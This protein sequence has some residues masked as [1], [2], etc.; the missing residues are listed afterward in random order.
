M[1]KMQ[2]SFSRRRSSKVDSRYLSRRSECRCATQ[3]LASSPPVFAERRVGDEGALVR[4]KRRFWSGALVAN[5]QVFMRKVTGSPRPASGRGATRAIDCVGTSDVFTERKPSPLQS[6]GRRVP[7]IWSDHLPLSPKQGEQD[8][9][10]GA[11]QFLTRY[12]LTHVG[13][14]SLCPRSSSFPRSC[15]YSTLCTGM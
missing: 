12:E 10:S 11:A 2:R 1:L 7:E 14:S 9:F 5:H 4:C 6:R 3:P 8:I 15:P 13:R